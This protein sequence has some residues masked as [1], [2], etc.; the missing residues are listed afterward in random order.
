MT[1]SL[2]KKRNYN[3]V[4]SLQMMINDVVVHLFEYLIDDYDNF[5]D[6]KSLRLVGRQFDYC[7][8][9]L[10]GKTGI[11]KITTTCLLEDWDIDRSIRNCPS[12]IFAREYCV[13]EEPWTNKKT[14]FFLKKC[15]D[16]ILD[17]LSCHCTRTGVVNVTKGSHRGVPFVSITNDIDVSSF[18][19]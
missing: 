19:R 11:L 6:M 16:N 15:P 12:W 2:K 3:F 5:K 7:M 18:Y 9:L 8:R 10:Q 17:A 14:T 4:V 1:L 13:C